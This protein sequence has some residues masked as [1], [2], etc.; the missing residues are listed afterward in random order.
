MERQVSF[1]VDSRKTLQKGRACINCRRRKVKCD[2]AKP[3]CGPC[4]GYSTAFSDCEYT[5]NGPCHSQ[6]LEEQISILQSRIE[7]LET[8]LRLRFGVSLSRP[9]VH[10][11]RSGPSGPSSPVSPTNTMGLGPLLTQFYLQQ[12]SR[13][14]SN[15]TPTS[16]MPT[17]LPF[18]VLQALVHN[19][20]HNA[21]CF[22]FFLDIQAFHDTVTNNNNNTHDRQLPPVLLNVMYLWG[23]HLSKDARITTYEP[24]FLVHAL[25]STAGSLSGA[26][27]R[28]ILHS[29]QASVLLAYYFIRDR[30]LLEARYHI[31]AAVS[32]ALSAGLHR[33]RAAPQDGRPPGFMPLEHCALPSPKC[34]AEEGERIGAWWTVLNLNNCHGSP[35]NVSYGSGDSGLN[36]DTPW[37]LETRDYVERPHL[38]PLCSSATVAKFLADVPDDAISDAA[39]HAKASILFEETNRINIRDR[40]DGPLNN[41][42]FDTLDRKIDALTA[43]LPP[44]RSKRCLIVHSL[45]RGATIQLHHLL[46]NERTASRA[47]QLLAARAMVDILR[48]TDVPKVGLI[49]PVLAPLWTT[50]SFVL[51]ADIAHQRNPET[52]FESESDVQVVIRAMEVFAPHCRLMTAQLDAVRYMYFNAQKD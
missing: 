30:R 46:A 26:H 13:T 44:I 15:Q 21:S 17:E 38:L 45:C 18:F 8:P 40:A 35:S 33:I 20:L 28:T 3:L 50:A 1:P 49:D 7:D 9:C 37:P 16:S 14:F 27:P 51:I 10:R 32:I 31:A 25:R 48:R 4:T 12:T 52:S 43:S 34:A 42:E 5:E 2:G 24:A 36:I 47:K 23:V 19:F 11:R 22:G 41:T 39:W 6:I 29:M